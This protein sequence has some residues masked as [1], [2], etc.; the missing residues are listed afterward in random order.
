MIVLINPNASARMTRDMHAVAQAQAGAI[1]V[2]A[3]TSEAG[4]PSIQGPE[5]GEAAVP[6]LLDLVRKAAL[7]H[8]P[9]AIVIGCFDDTGLEEARKIANCPVFGI[10]QAAYHLAAMLGGRFSVVTTMAVSVPI[11][12]DN[13]RSYGLGQS[14]ARVRASGIPVLE[15][16]K[17]SAAIISEIGQAIAEDDVTSVVLGCAGM[18]SLY[19][20]LRPNLGIPLI[21]GVR[22]SISMACAISPIELQ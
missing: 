5:D 20:T 7:E 6:P 4:P 15:L 16:E 12:E 22:A 19:E 11:L 13:I 10:G 1:P 21:D 9:R 18:A 8:S 2:V 17:A 3:W 14:L